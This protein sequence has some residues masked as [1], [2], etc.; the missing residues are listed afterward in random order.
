MQLLTSALAETLTPSDSATSGP[1]RAPRRPGLQP[2]WSISSTLRGPPARCSPSRT[3]GQTPA[4]PCNGGRCAARP[5]RR[6]PTTCAK[7]AGVFLASP[8]EWAAW[9]ARFP[10]GP[11][12]RP[13]SA[14]WATIPMHVKGRTLGVIGLSFTSP[15]PF[16][17]SDV[18]FLT[19]C[20]AARAG[21][22]SRA[23]LRGRAA[24]RRAEDAPRR[25]QRPDCRVSRLGDN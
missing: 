13:D 7:H 23:P 19:G 11:A 18:E 12:P 8:A 14:A 24:T 2:S 6:S 15:M 10:G 4:S 17:E 20:R 9:T 3:P 5:T 21:A 1:T 25:G 22:R 16:D